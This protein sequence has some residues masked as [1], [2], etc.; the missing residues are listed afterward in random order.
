MAKKCQPRTWVARWLTRNDLAQGARS[1][2][3][4]KNFLVLSLERLARKYTPRLLQRAPAD[5]RGRDK[6]GTA[7]QPLE[8]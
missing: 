1:L 4:Q 8:E 5:R 2:I 6:L 3:L 7:E